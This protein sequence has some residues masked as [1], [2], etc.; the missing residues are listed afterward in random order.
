MNVAQLIEILG[1]LPPD[2]PVRIGYDDRDPDPKQHTS[3][4]GPWVSL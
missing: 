3:H 4:G 2:H 1:D